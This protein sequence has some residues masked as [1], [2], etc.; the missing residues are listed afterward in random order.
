MLITSVRQLRLSTKRANLARPSGTLSGSVGTPSKASS[1]GGISSTRRRPDRARACAAVASSAARALGIVCAERA[2]SRTRDCRPA[3]TRCC[4]S[5]AEAP[6]GVQLGGEI[7]E[8]GGI[9]HLR[10]FAKFCNLPSHLP[11]WSRR[12]PASRIRVGRGLRI[13]GK[14]SPSKPP[15]RL[16]GFQRL[17][18]PC[19]IAKYCPDS[20]PPAPHTP[21]ARLSV[22]F[23]RWTMPR[24]AGRAYRSP[25]ETAPPG[26]C[27]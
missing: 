14:P 16:G 19:D 1:S 13:G 5:F 11:A 25:A 4:S 2:S 12:R 26:C 22:P 7:A 27:W 20:S 8:N 18:R 9:A 6:D 21:T 24:N 17:L 23:R 3:G 10:G 15:K